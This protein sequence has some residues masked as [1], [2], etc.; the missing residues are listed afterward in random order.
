MARKRVIIDCY[1][2]EPA[3][4]GVPPFLGTHPRIV[5][6]E[7]KGKAEYLT[8]DD[9]RIF[10]A[11]IKL[12]SSKLDPPTAKTRIDLL[13]RTRSPE[14]AKQLLS[15]AD[16]IIVVAGL[17][18]PGKYLSA[19]P[20]GLKEISK[21]LKPLKATKILT[22]PAASIGTQQ[23]GGFAAELPDRGI[24]DHI[25]EYKFADYREMQPAFTKGADVLKQITAERIIE[26]ET[27]RGC[28]RQSG[29]SFCTEPL[30]QQLCWREPDLIIEEVKKLTQNGAAR[31]RLGKQSCIYSYMKSSPEKLEQL[32]SGIKALEPSVFHIDNANPAFVTKELTELFVKYLTPGS[33]A[34]MGAETFDP[35]VYRL[36]NLNSSPENTL[37]AIEIINECG[38]SYGDNGM[39]ALLP[40]INILLGLEGES[41]RTLELNFQALK[42]M[43]KKDLFVRRINIRQVVPFPG[44]RLYEVA[45]DRYLRKNKHLYSAW[46]RKIREE[47]DL[48]ML[49]KIFPEGHRLYGLLA[50]THEGNVTFLRHPGSYPIIVGVRQRLELGRF[51]DVKVT[52]H[53]LRSLTGELI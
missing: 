29:C 48:P 37:Q 21:L 41:E 47:I 30:K 50:E 53:M 24:F 35:E 17:Q 45:G 6:G 5:F 15:S 23:M 52:G 18:T 13:N 44:T 19:Q 36:N 9:L 7:L 31:F 16:Q 4:L 26:I 42:D 51:Y 12:T 49:E 38:R 2:D 46:S 34:A 8:I 20:A 22:G 14:K 1:T 32:L 3:G 43:L 27:G 39:P 25:R 28:S 40:G 11:Q 33:T 10:S